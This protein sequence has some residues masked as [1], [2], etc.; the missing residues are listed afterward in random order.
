MEGN[1]KGSTDQT[2]DINGEESNEVPPLTRDEILTLRALM[3][4]A[5]IVLTTCP[6]AVRALSKR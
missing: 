4:D 6:I 2:E 3:R 5:S 1:E